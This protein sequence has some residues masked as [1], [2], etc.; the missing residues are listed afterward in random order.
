MRADIAGLD[1]ETPP[2]NQRH[3]ESKRSDPA[4]MARSVTDHR[5][6]LRKLGTA[7]HVAVAHGATG[8]EIFEAVRMAAANAAEVGNPGASLAATFRA[9]VH[10]GDDRF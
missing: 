8:D 4:R 6:A 10:D 7:V 9:S 1:V 5:E 2:A 3:L